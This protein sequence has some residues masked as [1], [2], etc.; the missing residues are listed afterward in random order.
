MEKYFRRWV[1]PTYTSGPSADGNG[2]MSGWFDDHTIEPGLVMG[3]TTAIV[4]H[5]LSNYYHVLS[6]HI[7]RRVIE[8]TNLAESSS[9]H[10]I[11]EEANK[12]PP[13]WQSNRSDTP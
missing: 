9:N 11:D 4:C 10:L 3:W 2:I 13:R 8:A 12:G 5:F 6:N 7:N 1:I